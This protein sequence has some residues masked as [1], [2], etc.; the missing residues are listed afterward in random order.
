MSDIVERLR[1]TQNWT[2]E[3]SGAWR[4]TTHVCDRAPFEAADE[5]EKLRAALSVYA[6]PSNWSVDGTFLVP[7]PQSEYRPACGDIARA[8]LGEK[9]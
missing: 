3:E 7:S 9:E 6:L 8:A 5:I 1:N 4:F 2:R